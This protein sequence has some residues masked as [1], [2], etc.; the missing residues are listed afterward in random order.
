MMWLDYRAFHG[1]AELKEER[2]FVIMTFEQMNLF[3]DFKREYIYNDSLLGHYFYLKKIELLDQFFK[4]S[5]NSPSMVSNFGFTYYHLH[6]EKID[7]LIEWIYE[8]R[9]IYGE[10]QIHI[11]AG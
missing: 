6:C 7:E 4:D 1:L 10:I 2:N 8:K 5:V 3:D 11:S 9:K